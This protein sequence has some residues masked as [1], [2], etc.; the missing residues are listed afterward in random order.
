[1]GTQKMCFNEPNAE[2]E[3]QEGAGLGGNWTK[4]VNGIKKGKLLRGKTVRLV[5][6]TGIDLTELMAEIRRETVSQAGGYN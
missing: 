5:T 2:F 6:H 1:M 3:I 4:T